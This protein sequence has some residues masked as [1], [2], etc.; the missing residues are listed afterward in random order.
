MNRRNRVLRKH[1]RAARATVASL[2]TIKN[3]RKDGLSITAT[4]GCVETPD[5]VRNRV[6]PVVLTSN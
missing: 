4:E 6:K 3:I 1:E 5:L 2:L